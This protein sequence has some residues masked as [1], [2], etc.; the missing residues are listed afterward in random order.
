MFNAIKAGRWKKINCGYRIHTWEQN[1]L[2]S[3]PWKKK[4]KL[5]EKNFQFLERNTWRSFC[6]SLCSV[7]KQQM[8][9]RSP[10]TNA[11]KI[12]AITLWIYT[13][14]LKNLPILWILSNKGPNCPHNTGIILNIKTLPVRLHCIWPLFGSLKESWQEWWGQCKL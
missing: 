6:H 10:V 12:S 1:K 4:E 14:V 11:I 7:P 9:I 13:L 8:F 5:T 2:T 3:L